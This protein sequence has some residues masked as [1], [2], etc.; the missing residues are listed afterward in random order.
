[1]S[2]PF[3]AAFLAVALG[4]LLGSV[5]FGLILTRAAGLGDIRKIGSGNI[6]A[7]NVLRTGNKTLAAGTLL[8]DGSKGVVT[9]LLA[10]GLAGQALAMLAGF[11]C[12]LGHLFPVWVAFRGGKGVATGIGVILGVSWPVGLGVCMIWLAMAGLFRRSSLAALA[13]FAVA[14]LLALVFAGGWTA[15]F[16]LVLAIL[17]MARHYDNITRLLAGTEPRMGAGK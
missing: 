9:V 12:V 8:L 6:G 15:L 11:A 14:P 2:T 4:Y 10:D 17:V 1:M 7:T 5:P 13:G 3:A 16:T